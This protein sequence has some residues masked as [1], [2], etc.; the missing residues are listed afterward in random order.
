MSR[1]GG[2]QSPDTDIW[3]GKCETLLRSPKQSRS[4]LLSSGAG[5]GILAGYLG[6]PGIV[7]NPVPSGELSAAANGMPGPFR[8][9]NGA[10]TLTRERTGMVRARVSRP[11]AGT[12]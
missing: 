11:G 3:Q 10:E 6:A 9:G 5:G 8:A 12:A 2:R 4:R 1:T 7:R